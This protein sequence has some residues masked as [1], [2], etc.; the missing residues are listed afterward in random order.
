[1]VWRWSRLNLVCWMFLPMLALAQE[2]VV[3]P[4]PAPQPGTSDTTPPDPTIVAAHEPRSAV[5]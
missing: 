2:P 5:R 1:M 4:E 3:T